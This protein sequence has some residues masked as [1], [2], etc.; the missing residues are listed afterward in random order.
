[1]TFIHETAIVSSQAQIGDNNY[2]GPF[3]II[4][5][6][7]VIGNNNQFISSVY[8]DN[9]T[10][11]KDNNQIY[12]FATVAMVPQDL[13]YQGEVSYVS[14]GNNNIIREH[15]T[16]HKGTNLGSGITT[17]GDHNFLMVGVHVAHDVSIANHVIIDN[18]V[19][20]AGHIEIDDFV[21]IGGGSGVH[22]FCNIG[23]HAFIGGMSGVGEDIVPYAMFAGERNNSGISGPNIVGLRRQQ[24]TNEQIYKIKDCYDILFDKNNLFNTNFEKISDKYRDDPVVQVIIDFINKPRKR[25]VCTIYKVF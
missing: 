13:K 25:Q 21:V 3:C 2:I 23:K 19:L 22:Q 15:V 17:I 5:D 9:G 12:P 6:D 8:L 4:N 18:N 10:R 7:V 20:L 24:F 1:M 11:I 14:I 16:I